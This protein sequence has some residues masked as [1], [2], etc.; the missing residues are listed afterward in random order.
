MPSDLL[1]AG[2]GGSHSHNGDH[3]RHSRRSERRSDHQL[4]HSEKTRPTPTRLDR[5]S[6]RSAVHNTHTS[7]MDDY[8]PVA[9]PTAAPRHRTMSRERNNHNERS[10]TLSPLKRQNSDKEKVSNSF[11]TPT[12]ASAFKKKMSIGSL[13]NILPGMPLLPHRSKD[14]IIT[15]DFNP[16]AGHE[17]NSAGVNVHHMSFNNQGGRNN[18][19]HTPHETNAMTSNSNDRGCPFNSFGCCNHH[20]EVQLAKKDYKGLW[21]VIQEVCPECALDH[22]LQ[23]QQSSML[24]RKSRSK[25][26]SHCSSHKSPSRNGSKPRSKSPRTTSTAIPVTSHSHQYNMDNSCKGINNNSNYKRTNASD[27]HHGSIKI[28]NANN[29]HSKSKTSTVKDTSRRSIPIVTPCPPSPKPAFS[30]SYFLLENSYTGLTDD[31]ELIE[32][33]LVPTKKSNVGGGSGVSECGSE[34]RS[35]SPPQHHRSPPLSSP[36]P[37]PYQ[38]SSYY[39]SPSSACSSRCSSSGRKSTSS[40][41]SGSGSAPRV[42]PPPFAANDHNQFSV[43]KSTRKYDDDNADSPTSTTKTPLS[44]SMNQR[45]IERS[46]FRNHERLC[47]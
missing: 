6:I 9:S 39:R 40:S 32:Q 34:T 47:W 19:H 11:F 21:K 24:R 43:P 20:P 3:D 14:V 30:S 18:K 23:H 36:K 8:S 7:E 13:K 12:A 22:L 26:P 16:V 46:T 5:S 27:Q 1:S 45:Q 31:L 38:Y 10:R 29:K 42:P 41:L 37:P 17:G 25:S 28:I 44:K 2:A 4:R 33:E 15:P 35:S